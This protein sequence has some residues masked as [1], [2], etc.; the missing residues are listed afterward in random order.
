ME[1]DSEGEAMSSSSQTL[2]YNPGLTYSGA[3]AEWY[4]MHTY[5]RH[6]K[7][8]TAELAHKSIETYL[9]LITTVHQWSDR[10]KQVELPLFPCYA[11]ARIASTAE[12]KV[13]VLRTSGVIGLVGAAKQGVSIPESQIEDVRTLLANKIP[14]DAYPFLKV[15]QRVRVRGGALD[16]LE[17][18]LMRKDR[19]QRLVVSVESIERS[20]SVC[21]EGYEVEA[22]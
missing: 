3:G 15:G 14:F 17:G 10:R 12:A 13:Q 2:T 22:I 7:R 11:F 20:L 8:I 21:I 1:C 4:A 18:I 19:K 16:G 5:P 9:P 6:E